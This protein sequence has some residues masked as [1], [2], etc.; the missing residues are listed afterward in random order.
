MSICPD[1]LSH[2][3]GALVMR[4]LIVLAAAAVFTGLQAAPASA[5]DITGAGSTFVF[6][7][8]S[9]WSAGYSAAHSAVPGTK[10]SYQSVGSS[11][12]IAQI[13]S[14]AVDFGASDAPLRPEELQ[15]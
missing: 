14:A 1:I 9:K 13:R 10:V 15:K 5:A 3:Q 12:G 11:Q 7:I 4:K 6:P 2:I 8:M